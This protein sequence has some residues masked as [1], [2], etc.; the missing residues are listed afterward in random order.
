MGVSIPAGFSDALRH[1]T[2]ATLFPVTLK[3]QSLLGF[4]MRCDRNVGAYQEMRD[5]VSIPAGFSD[6]LRLYPSD[7]LCVH[8]IVSIP[9]GFSDALRPVSPMA[10][11]FVLGWF[12][13][14]LGFLMRCDIPL[15]DNE[16][17]FIGFNPCWVF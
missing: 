5:Q 15:R 8:S 9:A 4:L 11:S 13:S 2:R 12:Q 7:A 16:S 10:C 1:P 6:A 17:G 14:L 3:F